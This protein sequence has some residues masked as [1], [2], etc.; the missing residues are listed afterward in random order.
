MYELIFQQ[1]IGVSA[2]VLFIS[3]AIITI[4]WMIAR[5]LDNDNAKKWAQNEIYQVIASAFLLG[6]AILF[7]AIAHNIMYL[8]I[9]L[10]NPGLNFSCSGSSCTYNQI[11][12]GIT[13]ITASPDDLA[14][15]VS[16]ISVTCGD[17]KPCHI[18]VAKSLL[19]QSF[20]SIKYYLANKIITVGWIQYISGLEISK[21]K[22][23]AVGN[24]IVFIYTTFIKIGFN[25]LL[26]LKAN[27]IFLVFIATSLFPAFII[28]GLV[29][30]SISILRRLG[31][32]LFAIAVGTYFVYPMLIIF[33]MSI[34]QP[35]PN[36]LVYSF[37][38]NS[39]FSAIDLGSGQTT[40]SNI[41]IITNT[42]SIPQ[43][44]L[45]WYEKILKFATNFIEKYIFVRLQSGEQTDMVSY[46]LFRAIYPGGFLDSMARI[47]VWILVPFII[48]LYALV[49]FIK[50]FSEFVGG[51]VDIAGLS[52]L[53]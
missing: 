36:Y 41:D 49:L 32:L 10:I 31:G 21:L 40:S 3:L 11:N 28:S 14:N 20:D 51:E 23:F 19:D 48:S 8:L 52:R 37:S 38:D 30:R 16:S 12:I 4:I 6:S 2:L 9:P 15:Q 33:S 35:D 44:D 53:L 17:D 42:K 45:A 1:W 34:V 29:F 50:G 24:N 27:S 39:G 25:F 22:P 5:A 18:M 43:E 47:T 7:I 13:S 46:T 26:L